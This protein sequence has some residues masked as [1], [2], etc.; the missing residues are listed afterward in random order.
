[1]IQSNLFQF[2][3]K[4]GWKTV[5]AGVQRQVLGYDDKVMLVKVKFEKDS[6][7][8]LHN[9]AHSQVTYVE[10]GT[11]EMTMGDTKRI[12]SKGDGYYAPP[13]T[14]HGCVCLEE[15]ML[16]DAFSPLRW[17]FIDTDHSQYTL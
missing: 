13:Y 2:E 5:G 8:Q 14:V 11:F 15:G 3:Q 16:V 12:I 6:C 1:M 7:G 4:S 10:S 17:E 9:H